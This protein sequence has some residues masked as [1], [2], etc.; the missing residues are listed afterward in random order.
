ME[1]AEGGDPEDLCG[2]GAS[3]L[4]ILQAAL[5][6][7]ILSTGFV[8]TLQFLVLLPVRRENGVL[9]VLCHSRA[10]P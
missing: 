2:A 9:R 5:P 4:G 10:D 1:T 7:G 8:K 6:P 3:S